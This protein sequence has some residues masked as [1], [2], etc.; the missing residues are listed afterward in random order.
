MEDTYNHMTTLITFLTAL[1]ALIAAVITLI[2][3]I[4]TLKNGKQIQEIHVSI[5]S[6]MDEFLKLAKE[7]SFAKGVKSEMDKQ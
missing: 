7:S 2:T 6:R 1:A 4:K 5:N 3:L